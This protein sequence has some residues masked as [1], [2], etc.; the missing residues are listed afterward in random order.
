MAPLGL[1]STQAARGDLF[2]RLHHQPEILVLPSVWDV[3]SA[4]LLA[5]L[6]GV[7]ALTTTSTGMAASQGHRAGDPAS[8]DQ[9][10]MVI[11]QITQAIEL[12]VS[13]DIGTGYG[14]T[15]RHVADAAA[16]LIE[17]G[18][19]GVTL[20]DTA[21]DLDAGLLSPGAQAERIAEA[22]AVIGGLGV[23]VV[24]N[25][26]TDAYRHE[27]G[28]PELRLERVLDRLWL[29]AQA[30]ADC[31]TAAGFPG[32]NVVGARSAALIRKLVTALDG[33]ALNLEIGGL[34][35]SVPALAGLGVRCLSVGSVLYR[36]A[37][38][39]MWNSVGEL[40][41]SGQCGVLSDATWH[42]ARTLQGTGQP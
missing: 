25:A 14:R 7:R 24:V 37:M 9:E 2:R 3:G 29:Y 8:F 16:S 27:V 22:A 1:L 30:G 20:R 40:L 23:P 5:Q 11:A 12:P 18:A 39:A 21:P 32:P 38:S 35:P 17:V 15:P 19:V 6:P 31:V 41:N 33:T 4:I 28:P 13:G 10:L 34:P 26:R 36:V 42:G